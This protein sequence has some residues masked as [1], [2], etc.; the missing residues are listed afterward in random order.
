MKEEDD[1]ADGVEEAKE[2]AAVVLGWGSVPP[3]PC[4]GCSTRDDND[5]GGG[6]GKR[7]TWAKEEAAWGSRPWARGAGLPSEGNGCEEEFDEAAEVAR[8]R[9]ARFGVEVGRT[10]PA[11]VGEGEDTNELPA[12]DSAS[13]APNNEGGGGGGGI[14]EKR[15]AIAPPPPP[16][17]PP[18]PVKLGS[19]LAKM[20]AEEECREV[21]KERWDGGR[22]AMGS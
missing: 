6:G 3:P 11:A 8:G 18:P 5:G 17:P 19:K 7:V 21:E 9:S 16:P 1:A 20:E 15:V 4:G 14:E 22:P 2:K 10:P 13:M 12:C